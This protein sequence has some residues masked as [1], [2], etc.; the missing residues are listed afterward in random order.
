MKSI[1]LTRGKCAIV[2]DSDYERLNRFKW[3]CSEWRG[4]KYAVRFVQKNGRCVN[5][6]MHREVLR[7]SNPKIKVD[8]RDRNGLNNRRRN[9]RRCSH[10][11]NLC[12]RRSHSNNSSGCRGVFFSME[13]G[14]WQA[15]IGSFGKKKFLGRFLLK[16][17][18]ER[19]YKRAAK[20]EFKT[21]SPL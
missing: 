6:K 18:A 11:Q 9:L 15:A 1:P 7:L 10:R 20:R 13:R 8:H 19:A 5:V 21:F 4:L 14:K 17:D 12:N 3:Q 16:S 2:D